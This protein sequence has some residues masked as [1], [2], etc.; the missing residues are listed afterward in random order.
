MISQGL[1]EDPT[2]FVSLTFLHKNIRISHRN[3]G[4]DHSQTG[5]PSMT[6]KCMLW[7]NFQ[8][9]QFHSLKPRELQHKDLEYSLELQI[10]QVLYER[11]MAAIMTMLETAKIFFRELLYCFLGPKRW[12][13]S[14]V[15][16]S[17]SICGRRFLVGFRCPVSGE[18]IVPPLFSLPSFLAESTSKWQWPT[19][20][21]NPGIRSP[22]SL[23]GRTATFRGAGLGSDASTCF[24]MDQDPK[25]WP[26][27]GRKLVDFHKEKMC[28][29]RNSGLYLPYVS[30]KMALKCRN[31][32]A[33]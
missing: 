17:L 29:E 18:N 28:I 7:Q 23:A 25:E 4:Y 14:I 10:E 9:P 1:Q 19:S 20:L 12:P 3:G 6:L 32:M 24:M 21:W 30:V 33:L 26:L 5:D 15:G 22:R 31:M 16:W 11:F 27:S 13:T 2:S 8:A